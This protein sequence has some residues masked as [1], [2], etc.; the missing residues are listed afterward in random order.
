MMSIYVILGI[1]I[2]KL[3]LWKNKIPNL[4][5]VKSSQT[6][7]GFVGFGKEREWDTPPTLEASCFTPPH[8]H[9]VHNRTTFFSFLFQL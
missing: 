5:L 9:N 4:S 8:M 3:G 2:N 7:W 6:T 1:M